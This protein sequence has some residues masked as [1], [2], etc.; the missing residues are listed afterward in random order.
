MKSI[1]TLAEHEITLV[2]RDETEF[3]VHYSDTSSLSI[4]TIV[5]R[6]KDSYSVSDIKYAFRMLGE[7]GYIVTEF[8]QSDQTEML[9]AITYEGHRFIQ[10]TG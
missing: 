2:Y 1:L 4:R 5:E 7:A 9:T 3:G 6:L 8:S 10:V